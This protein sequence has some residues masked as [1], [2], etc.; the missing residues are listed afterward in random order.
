MLADLAASYPLRASLATHALFTYIA[1][2][3]LPN[4]DG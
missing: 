2:V 1:W 4:A 3:S